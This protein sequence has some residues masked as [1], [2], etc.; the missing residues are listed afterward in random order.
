MPKSVKPIFHP[1]CAY[2]TFTKFLQSNFALHAN[3]LMYHL[4][5]SF[6]VPYFRTKREGNRSKF[7]DSKSNQ[8]YIFQ[9][10]RLLHINFHQLLTPPFFTYYKIKLTID[11]KLLVEKDHKFL[12]LSSRTEKLQNA[13]E[14]KWKIFFKDL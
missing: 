12:L 2:K 10:R 4:L 5:T 3:D 11:T 9:P 7:T 14:L 8:I 6:L 1:K 13:D